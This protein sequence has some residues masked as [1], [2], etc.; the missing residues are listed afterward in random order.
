[1]GLGALTMKMHPL[2]VTALPPLEDDTHHGSS[3]HVFVQV[4]V[5]FVIRMTCVGLKYAFKLACLISLPRLV[6]FD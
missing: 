6:C 1:M 2:V 5:S 3:L 4:C